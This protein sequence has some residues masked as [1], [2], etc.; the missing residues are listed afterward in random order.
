MRRIFIVV[1][2]FF[3]VLNTNAQGNL[4]FNQVKLV[5]TVETVN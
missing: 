5:S 1:T 2:V 4:Q 3:A